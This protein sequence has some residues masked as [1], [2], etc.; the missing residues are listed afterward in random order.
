MNGL[1]LHY[2]PKLLRGTVT[3]SMLIHEHLSQPQFDT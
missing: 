3:L 1:L 2:V